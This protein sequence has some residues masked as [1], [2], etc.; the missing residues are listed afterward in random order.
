MVFLSLAFEL[1]PV[2]TVGGVLDFERRLLDRLVQSPGIEAGAAPRI[3]SR[4]DNPWYDL[5]VPGNR[6]S[7]HDQ[8]HQD[9]LARPDAVV[10]ALS[11]VSAHRGLSL[12]LQSPP[13]RPLAYPRLRAAHCDLFHQP[14]IG[15][16]CSERHCCSL[17]LPGSQLGG[18]SFLDSP[19]LPYLPS[20]ACLEQVLAQSCA[21][22]F[23]G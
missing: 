9:L 2:S 23:S 1:R 10:A 3:F 18:K 5:L 7:D 13:H 16:I 15:W 8:R 6:Q 12:Q 22:P 4:P 21:T 19:D 20:G 11:P 14:G 17:R